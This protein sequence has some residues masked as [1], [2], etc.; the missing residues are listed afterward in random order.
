MIKRIIL[1][2]VASMIHHQ[3]GRASNTDRF[4]K[5]NLIGQLQLAARPGYMTHFPSEPGVG[6]G[7]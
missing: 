7:R 4:R 6:A 2:M 1:D 3:K 5:R